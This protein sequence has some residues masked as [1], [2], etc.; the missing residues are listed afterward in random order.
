VQF[1][2]FISV[3]I[4][5]APFSVAPGTPHIWPMPLGKD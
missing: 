5:V 1:F 2:V 4:R 3:A